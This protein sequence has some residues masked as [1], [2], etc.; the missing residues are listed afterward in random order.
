[1]RHGS[2]FTSKQ[3]FH[4]VVSLRSENLRGRIRTGLILILC[5]GAVPLV[6]GQTDSTTET[7]AGTGTLAEVLKK[8]DA[9]KLPRV[10]E[11]GAWSSEPGYVYYAGKG[12]IPGIDAFY[13]A[14]LKRLGWKDVSASTQVT[15]QYSDRLYQLDDILLQVAL[16]TGSD[17]GVVS[18]SLSVFGN[19]DLRKFPMPEDAEPN[20]S[21]SPVNVSYRSQK[22]IPQISEAVRA[23]LTGMG[24]REYA[25]F[26]DQPV[27]PP[28]VSSM[29]FVNGFRKLQAVVHRDP[30]KPAEPG[31]AGIFAGSILSFEVLVP[32]GAT[33]LKVDEYQG[34][35]RYR[36]KQEP[37]AA[38]SA[39]DALAAQHAWVNRTPDDS[40]AENTRTYRASEG[41]SYE[42]K[43]TPDEGRGILVE[44]HR[45][46]AEP[47]A[48]E[49]AS[50]DSQ[51][52]DA[53]VPERS[54]PEMKKESET[55]KPSQTDSDDEEIPA[56]LAA[57]MR[58]AQK[59]VQ[60][61]VG[62]LRQQLK[63]IPG[64]DK[65]A[66]LLEEEM[67]DDAEDSED[68]GEP[69]MKEDDSD[70]ESD[71]DTSGESD[72]ENAPSSDSSDDQYVIPPAADGLRGIVKGKL[73]YGTD[74]TQFA[75]ALA[76][77]ATKYGESSLMIYLSDKPMK[78][79]VLRSKTIGELSAYDLAADFD[80]NMLSLS[81]E[82]ESVSIN[83]S[84]KSGS[85]SLS[86]TEI[87]ADVQ[88]QDGRLKGTLKMDKPQDFF[89]KPFLVELTI[90][91]PMA[92]VSGQSASGASPDVMVLDETF[93]FPVPTG[94]SGK[95]QESSP[96]RTTI[97]T[98]HSQS[99]DAIV[100]FYEDALPM[101][102]WKIASRDTKPGADSAMLFCLDPERSLTIRMKREGDTTS[103][104]LIGRN[105]KTA[106]AAGVVPPQGK[107]KL[108]IGNASESDVTVEV[109]GKSYNLKAGEGS[110]DPKQARKIDLAP[111][112][113]R[114]TVKEKGGASD[115][116]EIEGASGT[117][118]G[119][120]VL[121]KGKV[122]SN[123][124][125]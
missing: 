78:L 29:T 72:S 82:K 85:I 117:A 74:I 35:F 36:S 40:A 9:R 11:S 98:S 124:L 81:L 20:P 5:L 101:A 6:N 24:W 26:H 79:S 32:D 87:L 80:A 83:A 19:V 69:E 77:P 76:F 41:A 109:A 61:E 8:V 4:A 73:T 49:V 95:S 118:W 67:E 3:R 96:Y 119:A 18:V 31:T 10:A 39:F 84:L 110:E 45:L 125:Y 71:S 33:E 62:K 28:H 53:D 122:F 121:P 21:P 43:F 13:Q 59:E 116:E 64:A 51:S 38:K 14:E 55:D 1:M 105:E 17:E 2:S 102:G 115:S 42:V 57:A 103:L 46:P 123:L 15:E 37:E 48:P 52:D 89:D 7:V 65:F 23:G 108:F 100:K 63:G 12:S 27:S 104:S 34:S 97:T 66:D 106:R 94:T 92:T 70:T 91:V 114:M 111:G 68:A 58:D 75:H 22:S 50:A 93:D 60:A 86:S 25:P 54:E 88:T 99:L 56:E 113:H 112:R 16:G 47:E 90:D 107:F 44:V 120:I 30:K